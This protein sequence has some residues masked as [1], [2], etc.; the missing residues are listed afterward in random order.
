MSSN[1]RREKKDD[2]EEKRGEREVN[3]W[4]EEQNK[5]INNNT[6]LHDV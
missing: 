3:I 5:S 4:T 2:R 1:E 6:S